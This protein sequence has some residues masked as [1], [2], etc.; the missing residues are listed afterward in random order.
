MWAPSWQI[1]Q[2]FN[3]TL[4]LCPI[5]NI[6]GYPNK[7]RR[8]LDRYQGV[9]WN[10]IQWQICKIASQMWNC[11]RDNR[12]AF[13]TLFA[14]RSRA[15]WQWFERT[16]HAMKE[17]QGKNVQRISAWRDICSHLA[18]PREPS[19]TWIKFTDKQSILQC[20]RNWN[21]WARWGMHGENIHF[22]VHMTCLFLLC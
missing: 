20:N 17:K 4:I 7:R 22:S 10:H 6:S 12:M 5:T 21:A 8:I 11:W 1:H 18:I 9:C 19:F 15:S 14:P 2:S 16:N 13:S 3:K